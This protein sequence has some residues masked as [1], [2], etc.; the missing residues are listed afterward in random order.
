VLRTDHLT[1]SA[2]HR[3][4][5]PLI[6]DLTLAVGRGEAVGVTGPSGCGKSTLLRSVAGLID[7][8]DGTV[9]LDDKTPAEIGWP[10]FR[11][12]VSLVPQRPVVWDGTVLSNLQRPY[13]FRSSSHS[14][15]PEVG[16]EMLAC[17]GLGSKIDSQATELSEGERQRVCLVRSL[18]TKPDFVLLDEPTSAL[19]GEAVAWVEALLARE[20]AENGLGILIATHDTAQAQR[21]CARVIDLSPLCVA[22]E[23]AG[24]VADA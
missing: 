19:D 8:I 21:F 2:D 6:A 15:T 24:E 13:A 7:P 3:S 16:R 5:R 11:S 20:M 22:G 9:T 23:A 18:L 10:K 4:R 1:V 14:F 17:V 12:R